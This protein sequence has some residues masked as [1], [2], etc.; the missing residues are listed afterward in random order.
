MCTLWCDD[1]CSRYDTNCVLFVVIYFW[2]EILL[3][4]IDMAYFVILSLAVIREPCFRVGYG[5]CICCASKHQLISV[6]HGSQQ[7]IKRPQHCTGLASGIN[8]ILVLPKISGAFN[9]VAS[10]RSWLVSVLFRTI[11]PSE[12]CRFVTFFI[13]GSTQQSGAKYI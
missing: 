9:Y 2:L 6:N 12:E 7:H 4:A 3:V 10:Q 11:L 1:A 5:N 8:Y 13:L